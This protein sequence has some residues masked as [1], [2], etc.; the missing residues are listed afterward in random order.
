MVN[1][2]TFSPILTVVLTGR[3]YIIIRK[4]TYDYQVLVFQEFFSII[5]LLCRCEITRL[6]STGIKQNRLFFTH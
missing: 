1:V 4:G 5:C 3:A 6:Q 2:W